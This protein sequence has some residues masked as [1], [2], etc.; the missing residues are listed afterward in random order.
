MTATALPE[1]PRILR[2]DL[3]AAYCGVSEG[4]F[5]KMVNDGTYP[6]PLIKRPGVVAWD[7]TQ[8]DKSID[9]MA[10]IDARSGNTDLE[11]DDW[12]NKNA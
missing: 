7:K 1:W 5:R 11:I 3:A 2:V 8:I 10:G 4:T 12:L 9:R 6:S